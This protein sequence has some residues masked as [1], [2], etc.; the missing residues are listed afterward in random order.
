MLVPQQSAKQPHEFDVADI[1]AMVASTKGFFARD[2][3]LEL[4]WNNVSV[5]LNVGLR[6]LTVASID[7]IYNR[8]FS[9]SG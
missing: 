2:Y 1:Q 7:A 8:S 4:G 9:S 6:V 3:S 5:R